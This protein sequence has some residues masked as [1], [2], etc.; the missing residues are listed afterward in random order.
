MD[1]TIDTV[2]DVSK[3]PIN[4]HQVYAPMLQGKMCLVFEAKWTSQ[5]AY[6]NEQA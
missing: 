2:R 3:F 5:V 6:G 4:G 1:L